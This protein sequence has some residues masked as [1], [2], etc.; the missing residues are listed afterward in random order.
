[1][2]WA[3][4]AGGA[5]KG[6]IIHIPRVGNLR[7][8]PAGRRGGRVAGDETDLEGP[9]VGAGGVF[10][11]TSWTLPSNHEEIYRTIAGNL[12]RGLSITTNAPLTTVMELVTHEKTGATI[13]HF[14]NFDRARPV[15]LF[16][17]RVRKPLNRTV[18]SVTLLSPD[19]DD[20]KPLEFTESGGYVRF[21]VPRLNLYAMTVID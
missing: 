3:E 20:P 17:V 4:S 2:A 16:E 9:Y 15:S 7:A 11:A 18:K 10:P 19:S 13:A 12:P 1:V 6:K 5:G 14:V 8:G 21:R